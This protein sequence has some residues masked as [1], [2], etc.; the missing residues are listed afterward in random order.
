MHKWDRGYVYDT[1]GS[2]E[3]D[4]EPASDAVSLVLLKLK[5]KQG[6]F[7][8]SAAPTEASKP[9]I[10]VLTVFLLLFSSDLKWWKR[11]KGGGSFKTGTFG[12]RA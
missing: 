9:E 8:S 1:Q 12:A 5:A 4:S 11:L 6:T 3:T 10:T 2:R 7:A